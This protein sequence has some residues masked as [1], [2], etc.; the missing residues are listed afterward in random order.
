M[1]IAVS[2]SN[3]VFA[4]G[5]SIA[6]G[7]TG[8]K[9][10]I[11]N[12]A[13]V[14]DQR[15]AG[16]SVTPSNGQYTLDR[17]QFESTASSK[18]T[19]QQDGGGVTPPVGFTDYL[20]LTVASSVSL[21]SSDFFLIEQSIEGYN[22][23]D[24]NFGSANAKTVTLS[25]WVRSSLTGT[26][27]GAL[28]NN[29]FNRAYIFTYSISAANTW[30]YK[31]ITVA[32]CPDGNWLT[33]NGLGMFVR[34]SLGTGSDYS[35][36][37][38]NSWLPSVVW[39][40]TGSVNLVGTNGA[41]FYITGVQ[42]EAG[43]SATSFEYRPFTTELQL[44]QRYYCKTYNIGVV[45]GTVDG[46]GSIG[47]S[48]TGNLYRPIVNWSYP[49]QMRA[50]PTITFYS[51]STGTIGKARDDN[52]GADLDATS[53]RTGTSGTRWYPVSQPASGN[54]IFAQVVASIEL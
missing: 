39:N 50:T 47:G 46:N 51:P 14:I 17:W 4:D 40:Q 36:A 15:N 22:I 43:S 20:G 29:G 38:A 49:V 9:N 5:S 52:S 16:A 7:F 11:I 27:S 31:T 3:I 2:G 12:G 32:G 53:Y 23:A 21:T 44:C 10:R 45:P 6:S 34:F 13:M 25:F 8:F 30:E 37:T 33:T 41:T 42:L 24:L 48:G 35:S 54:D 28:A 18:F 19:A 26:F 1:P